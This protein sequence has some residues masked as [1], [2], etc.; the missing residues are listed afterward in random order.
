MCVGKAGCAK[1]ALAEIFKNAKRGLFLF[2]SLSVVSVVV[3][4]QCW[5]S[6]VSPV[7]KSVCKTICLLLLVIVNVSVVF[8]ACAPTVTCMWR[9]RLRATFLS[10]RDEVD[11]GDE[12][13]IPLKTGYDIY[14]LLA[15]RCLFSGQCVWLGKLFCNFWSWVGMC[16][17]Q[18]C[19]TISAEFMFFYRGPKNLSP[20]K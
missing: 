9:S 6:R 7:V 2:S 1:C 14:S 20:L 8:F 17:L 11:A 12:P 19:L 13:S 3:Q 10:N 4:L 16:E 15:F 5:S 18:M